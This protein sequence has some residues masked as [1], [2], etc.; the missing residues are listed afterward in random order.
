MQLLILYSIQEPQDIRAILS[1]SEGVVRIVADTGL[2]AAIDKDILTRHGVPN[3]PLIEWLNCTDP[4]RTPE[5]RVTQQSDPLFLRHL[6][7]YMLR[8][9]NIDFDLIE[10]ED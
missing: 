10:V 2:G 9:Y 8:C 1:W 7:E 5:Q 6:G 3:R 4:E